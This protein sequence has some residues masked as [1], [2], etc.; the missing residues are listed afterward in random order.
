MYLLHL[1]RNVWFC[2]LYSLL[3]PPAFDLDYINEQEWQEIPRQQLDAALAKLVKGDAFEYF[4]Q[5]SIHLY[6]ASKEIKLEDK[7]DPELIPTVLSLSSKYLTILDIKDAPNASPDSSPP[8]ISKKETRKLFVRKHFALVNI[9]KIV[10]KKSDKERIRI[11]VDT[12]V[13]V[14]N[15]VCS[16]LVPHPYTLSRL[17][18]DWR[19]GCGDARV[20]S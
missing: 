12:H 19:C 4:G 16:N 7:L 5:D 14:S 1:I 15:R 2:F 11:G 13:S 6:N 3:T 9:K 10:F 8:T 20:S 18:I 17:M